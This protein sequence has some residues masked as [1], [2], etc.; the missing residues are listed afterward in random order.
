MLPGSEIPSFRTA[1]A[2]QSGVERNI[3]LSTWGG[4]GDQI[5]AEP[6]LRFAL[7]RFKDVRISLCSDLPELFAH[8]PFAEVLTLAE[9]QLRASEF[10]RFE[11]IQP[12]SSL[13]WE[14]MSH[15]VVNCVDFPSLCAFRF[16]L[17]NASK[18]VKLEP[19]GAD[20]AAV[21]GYLRDADLYTAQGKS[22]GLWA[23]VHP[24]KHW[25]SKTFP[26]DW[27]NGVLRSMLANG[28][29][30]VLIGANCD[31]NRGTVDVDTS[32]CVDLRSKLSIMETVS[33]LR[34]ARVLITNDS[35]PLH[36]AA[37]GNAWIGYIATV[38][39][40]DYITHW[41]GPSAEFGWRMEN[42]S[43]GGYWE[44]TEVL[45]NNA[46]EISLE[47]VAEDILRSW[48]PNPSNVAAWVVEK[49]A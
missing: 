6:T 22:N 48:L 28:I 43:L 18:K 38:K 11:T 44:R 12:P 5:C 16:Q 49:L 7:E 30:P 25:A 41:R 15:M 31:D 45:P 34:F 46:E 36:M 13:V 29:T 24:G 32:A 3:L 26:A 40:P 17:P 14:F 19:S 9:G 20:F 27:W 10:L 33:L 23:V 47:F 4:I 2:I 21:I 39:H 1:I 42:L 8:L 37:C 35:S